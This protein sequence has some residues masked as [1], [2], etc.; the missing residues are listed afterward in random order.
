MTQNSSGALFDLLY[1]L[2]KTIRGQKKS[3]IPYFQL[4]SSNKPSKALEFF[5]QTHFQEPA[6]ESFST[7][8]FPWLVSSG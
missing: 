8:S 3:G 1:N 4:P 5:V 7:A 6:I 2:S